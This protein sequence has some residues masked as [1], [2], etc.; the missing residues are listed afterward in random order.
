M[1]KVYICSP[2]GGDVNGNLERAKEYTSYALKCG[3]APVTPH[4]YA[5]CLDDGDPKD[6]ELGLAAGLS[7]LLMC[8]ELWVF[9]SNV[10][11]GR[12]EEIK[13]AECLNIPIRFLSDKEINEPKGEK[14]HEHKN[15]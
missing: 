7:L 6:R 11:F 9:G 1:K 13:A 3:A 15:F 5:L 14:D 12:R 10:S 2:L 4:F 8:D